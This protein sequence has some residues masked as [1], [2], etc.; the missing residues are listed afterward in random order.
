MPI[1]M[2]R[3]G[4]SLIQLTLLMPALMVM[5]L[6]T[7]AW[8]HQTMNF[9]SNVKKQQVQHLSLTR[10]ASQFRQDVRRCQS[11]SVDNDQQICLQNQD[12]SEITYTI[13]EQAVSFLKK[14]SDGRR[15]R[16]EQFDLESGAIPRFDDTELPDWI[17]LIV[18]RSPANSRQQGQQKSHSNETAITELHVR[19]KL[20]RWGANFSLDRELL[21]GEQR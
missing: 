19:S 11:I 7:V 15:T 5:F 18:S 6:V 21:Q 10:L 12:L 13:N 4:F 17:S 3:R 8:L 20:N 2:N 9:S 1:R 14:S 16:Q